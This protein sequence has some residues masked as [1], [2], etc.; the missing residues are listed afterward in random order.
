MAAA[1]ASGTADT[2]LGI[3]A[4]AK[5]L[6]LDFV[7]LLKERYDLIIPRLYYESAFLEPLLAALHQPS[8]QAEVKAL[9]GYDTSHMGQVVAEL[10]KQQK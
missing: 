8:F 4:A 3:R 2:G 9:G 5:A 1:I 6:D 10:G 7:P